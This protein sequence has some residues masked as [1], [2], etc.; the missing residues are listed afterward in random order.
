MCASCIL[1]PRSLQIELCEN[2]TG[3]AL[4]RGGYGDVFRREHEGQEV[5]VKVLRTYVNSDSRK[6]ARVS[7]GDTPD[8]NHPL[9]L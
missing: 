6:I 8:S 1:L 7:R 4:Y 2:P 5:A 3:F 9:E